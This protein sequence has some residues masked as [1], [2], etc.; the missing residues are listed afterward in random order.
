[1]RTVCTRGALALALVTGCSLPNDA[2]HDPPLDTTGGGDDHDPIED[3]GDQ[4]EDT[5]PA[6]LA[7]TPTGTLELALPIADASVRRPAADLT[8][9]SNDNLLHALDGL[10]TKF[11]GSGAPLYTR[12]WGTLTAADQDGNVFVTGMFDRVIDFGLGRMSPHGDG[13]A[14]LVKLDADGNTVFA[15]ELFPCG[16]LAVV[17]IAV[18]ADGRIAVSGT[19]MG[20]SVLDADAHELARVPY[21]GDVAFDSQGN[22]IIG[23]EE[24]TD[25]VIRK[26]D[27][28][29]HELFRVTYGDGRVLDQPELGVGSRQAAVGVAV[30]KDDNIFVIGEFEITFELVDYYIPGNENGDNDGGF[31]LKLDPEGELQWFHVDSALEMNDIEVDARGDAVVSITTLGSRFPLIPFIE[32]FSGATGAPLWAHSDMPGQGYGP[33]G[34]VAIDSCGDVYWAA[35]VITRFDVEGNDEAAFLVKFAL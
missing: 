13:H 27:R 21:V 11:S 12:T 8:A 10:L 9:D 2:A 16:T 7:R 14:F 32:K 23:G 33:A 3:D 1:M 28:Q 22:L 34:G 20:T 18:A 35:S 4:S 26:L 24:N 31:T 19:G 6:C 5:A 17:S 30:D 25:A 29:G 15:E